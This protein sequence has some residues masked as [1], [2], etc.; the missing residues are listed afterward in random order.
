MANLEKNASLFFENTYKIKLSAVS[1]L[2]A[3][4]EMSGK[5]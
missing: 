1:P 3:A 5:F 2:Y 4:L